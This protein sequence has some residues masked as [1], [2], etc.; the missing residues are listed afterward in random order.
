[1]IQQTS[2]QEVSNAIC[3]CRVE[4][5]QAVALREIVKFRELKKIKDI[6]LY[7][8][9]V[10]KQIRETTIV[11]SRE[12]LLKN[13]FGE[14]K[15]EAEKMTEV[16]GKA[17]ITAEEVQCLLMRELAESV[18]KGMQKYTSMLDKAVTNMTQQG[19]KASEFR[20]ILRKYHKKIKEA[21][22]SNINHESLE[23]KVRVVKNVN[24]PYKKELSNYVGR[25]EQFCREYFEG[26]YIC[27]SW[28][29]SVQTIKLDRN[30]EPDMWEE[31]QRMAVIGKRKHD[32]EL[33]N[34]MYQETVSWNGRM[35][36]QG[37]SMCRDL[38]DE[39]V[40]NQSEKEGYTAEEPKE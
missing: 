10:W 3:T 15:R 17:D 24:S 31:W 26:M 22:K 37:I 20:E 21:A 7:N 1:L 4:E 33:T 40:I 18:L 39:W 2:Q 27:G 19:V 35:Q 34:V 13:I 12:G 16:I 11:E 38:H 36:I 28:R 9:I 6:E 30:V 32:E 25:R 14:M 29:L 8:I 23:K 5:L